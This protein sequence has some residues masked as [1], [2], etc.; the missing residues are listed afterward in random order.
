MSYEYKALKYKIKYLALRDQLYGGTPAKDAI[1][2]IRSGHKNLASLSDFKDDLDVVM[3]AVNKDGMNLKYASTELK[4]N[5]DVCI[6]AI[7]QTKKALE[8]VSGEFKT[9]RLHFI[10]QLKQ[11]KQKSDVLSFYTKS[12]FKHDKEIILLVLKEGIKLNQILTYS[13]STPIIPS[14]PDIIM[15]DK[16]FALEVV[17]IDGL[18]IEFLT[19]GNLKN[20]KEIIM[21]AIEQNP[22]VI[23]KFQIPLE[24]D[25]M[26]YLD[27]AMLVLTKDPNLLGDKYFAQIKKKPELSIA[28][29][30]NQ[31]MK[32]DDKVTLLKLLVKANPDISKSKEIIK[33][34][35]RAGINI[36]TLLS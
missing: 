2:S 27:I 18:N 30:N 33:A 34:C 14:I 3:A 21:A 1:E 4:N 11:L 31:H 12:K 19:K 10:E 29:C 20:N 36:D 32:P 25:Q 15:T 24:A 16:Q 28:V 35:I 22:T 23:T 6:S 8:F 26:N 5:F 9:G 7:N 13:S 17:R